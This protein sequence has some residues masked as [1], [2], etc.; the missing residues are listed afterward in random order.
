ML[1]TYGGIYYDAPLKL[2]P[3]GAIQICV[4]LLLYYSC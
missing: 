2:R 1:L 4:L 3:L